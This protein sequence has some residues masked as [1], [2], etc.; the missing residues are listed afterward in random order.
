MIPIARRADGYQKAPAEMNIRQADIKDAEAISAV[1]YPLAEKYIAH[2][3]SSQGRSVLLASMTAEAIQRY[4]GQGYHYHVAQVRGQAI[5]VVGVRENRHLYHLFVA[6]SHERNGIARALWK[7]AL[8][9]CRLTG[10]TGEFTANASRTA[11]GL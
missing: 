5:G 11:Q 7:T 9:A 1:M 3:L 6:E 8:Q 4:F 2:E 10:N